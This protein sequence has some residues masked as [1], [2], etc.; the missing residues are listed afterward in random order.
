[1]S[2]QALDLKRAGQIV[3]RRKVLVAVFAGLGIVVGVAYAVLNPPVFTSSA[4]V[5]LSPSARNVDT[6]VVIA[7]SDPVLQA[8]CPARPGAR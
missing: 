2:G 8:R 3:R 7:S 4:L 6:Q 5:V 1:M